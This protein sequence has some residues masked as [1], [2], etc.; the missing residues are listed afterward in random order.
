MVRLR[1]YQRLA[2]DFAISHKRCGLFLP[3]GAG[4][5][6]VT[7]ETLWEVAPE[8]PVLI[9]GPK[10]IM[11]STWYDE[12]TKF[13]FP[14]EVG[15]LMVDERGRKLSKRARIARYA[16]AASAGPSIWF[17]NRDL[18]ADLVSWHADTHTPWAFST[19]VIDEAQSF[20]N[21]S[22]RRFKALRDVSPGI[23][24]LIELTG[25]PAPNG[26]L[27]VWSLMWLVD[28]GARLGA[29]M[30]AY[31]TRWFD[32]TRR[33]ANN[34]PIDWAPKPGAADEIRRR[35]SDVCIT[36]DDVRSIMPPVTFDDVS[37]SLSGDEW[38]EYRRLSREQVLAFEDEYGS[39]E[40]A[41]AL[42]GGVLRNRLRQFASGTAYA[43]KLEESVDASGNAVVHA[44]PVIKD[45]HHVFGVVHTEKVEATRDIIEAAGSPVLVVYNFQSERD[46]LMDKLSDLDIEC[47]DGSPEM[48]RRWNAREIPAMLMQPASAGFGLN[49]QMGGHTLVW[50][51]LPE[52]LELYEQTN[53]R[54]VRSGQPDPVII[55]RLIAEGT[56]DEIVA[57]DL[58]GKASTQG[59]VMDALKVNRAYLAYYEK[60]AAKDA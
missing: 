38:R 52:S 25:T 48:I 17:L 14:F 39:I 51:T 47:F 55:H 23:D 12:I 56:V 4:K 31:K 54:L 13:G 45:G 58:D 24:R 59:Y 29:S 16:E 28:G 32:V 34:I 44:R 1:P 46:M 57:A 27:D 18:V 49:L 7:L 53:G 42:N 3:I 9:I 10:Q 60:M 21:P 6:L 22:S 41:I 35:M 37:V 11:R 5:T 19:I 30:N 40:N 36:F 43:S 15:S 33:T 26:L 20:K 50:F 8:D 2:C